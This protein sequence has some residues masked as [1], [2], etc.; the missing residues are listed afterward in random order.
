MTLG[1][2]DIVE[3][4]AIQPAPAIQDRVNAVTMRLQQSREHEWGNLVL[5]E[6]RD[7]AAITRDGERLFRDLGVR[8]FVV[9][10]IAGARLLAIFMRRTRAAAVYTYT[11]RPG[12]DFGWLEV[13]PGDLIAVNDTENGITL[14]TAMVTSMRVGEDWEVTLTLQEHPSGI[15]A[16]TL[17]LPRSSHLPS[18]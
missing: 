10:P 3:M 14:Q 16:D 17:V 18:L 5:P 9:D 1:S 13:A 8:R 2:D 15:Y 7:T 12:D 11:V 6:Y 4:G